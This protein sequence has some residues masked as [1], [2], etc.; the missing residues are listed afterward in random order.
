MEEVP[1]GAWRTLV[2]GRV[3]ERLVEFLVLPDIFTGGRTVCGHQTKRV[4]PR[5]REREGSPGPW[6]ASRL[7]PEACPSRG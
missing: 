2:V 5:Q 3:M 4:K 1:P 7:L 6:G